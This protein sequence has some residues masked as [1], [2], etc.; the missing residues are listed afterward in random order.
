MKI[1]Y[2]SFL[3]VLTIVACFLSKT[4]EPVTENVDMYST[5]AIPEATTLETTF[6]SNVSVNESI[7]VSSFETNAVTTIVT[8]SK[9]IEEITIYTPK[10][11]T[12]AQLSELPELYTTAVSKDEKSLILTESTSVNSI[13]S[14]SKNSTQKN[15]SKET[16]NSKDTVKETSV[17]KSS[18]QKKSS[19]ETTN[20][21]DT[22]SLPKETRVVLPVE[23]IQQL[24]ELP[25]GCEVTST[26]IVMNYEGIKVD[27]MVL[28]T[29]LPKM[30]FPDKNGFWESPWNKFVG[31]PNLTYYGCYSPVIIET[32]NACLKKNEIENFEIVDISDSSME[33]LYAQIDDGHPVIVWATMFMKESYTG[34]S[35]WYLQDGTKF[36]WRS[37]EHC[38]VLIGYDTDK[39]TVILSDPYDSKGTVEYDAELFESRYT[40]LYKQALIIRRIP[41]KK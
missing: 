32:F 14:V 15:S 37:N 28:A 25:A 30:E 17:S 7:A 40:E 9:N 38:L 23:N 27:K 11:N 3:I 1:R 8:L 13:T 16:K 2:L 35:S 4:D 19:K 5:S 41:K 18:E 31:N 12:Y 6:S 21:K 39:N 22:E 29:F 34:R 33:E 10:A 36:N 26:A 24:P 20:S